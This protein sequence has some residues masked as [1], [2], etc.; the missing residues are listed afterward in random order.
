[1]KFM[2][3][4]AVFPHGSAGAFSRSP[5]TACFTP[6][7]KVVPEMATVQFHPNVV[8]CKQEIRKILSFLEILRPQSLHRHAVT[9]QV[10]HVDPRGGIDA[11]SAASEGWNPRVPSALPRVSLR[12]CKSA[13]NRADC[14]KSVEPTPLLPHHF[15]TYHLNH[16]RTHQGPVLQMHTVTGVR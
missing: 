8:F 4:L 7:T 2:A 16:P 3:E 10:I 15:R 6:E 13:N 14:C 9:M 12:P 11:G 5:C 1:M